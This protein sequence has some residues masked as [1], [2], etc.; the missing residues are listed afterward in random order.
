MVSYLKKEL[1]SLRAEM[2]SY[3]QAIFT[4]FYNGKILGII[5]THVDDFC[6]YG[7]KMFRTSVIDKIKSKFVVKSEESLDFNYLGLNI[8]QKE[9]G[10]SV[11]Q[12]EYVKS[13][14]LVPVNTAIVHGELIN[15]EEETTLRKV[16]GKLNWI[17]T[18]TRPDLSFDV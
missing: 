1:L 7:T 18:Q 11:S 17:A 9:N 5:S 14:E 6:W 12:D 3:N 15:Q 10:I 13:L 8:S 2:S 16:N 4:W